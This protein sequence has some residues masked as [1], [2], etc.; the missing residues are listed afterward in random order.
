VYVAGLS[1]TVLPAA[2]AGAT[3]HVKSIKGKFQGTMAP[4]T[5][6]ELQLVPI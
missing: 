3:F 5:P 1:M 4:T 2:R 6:T